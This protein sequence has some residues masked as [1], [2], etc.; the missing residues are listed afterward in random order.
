MRRPGL[1]GTLWPTDDEQLLLR[2]ALLPGPGAVTAWREVQPRF[3]YEAATK[4]E[5]RILPLVYRNLTGLGV[6]DPDLGKMKGLYR[7]AWYQNQLHLREAAAALTLL[8]EAGIDTLVLKGAPLALQC[9][10]ELGARP[11]GDV[12]L[13][14]PVAQR[15]EALATL[16]SQGWVPRPG[17]LRKSLGRHGVALY[18]PEGGVIDVHWQLS[19]AL[20]PPGDEDHA[21]DDFFSAS[22]ALDLAGTPARAPCLADTLLHVVVHGCHWRSGAQLHWI[23]D[24][25][26]LI[27]EGGDGLA[28]DRLVV[29]AEKRGVVLTVREGLRYLRSGV[30]APVPP[31]VL[32]TLGRSP[33]TRRDRL[34]HRARVQ[35]PRP[36]P[37][38]GELPAALALHVH[39]S[40]H[41]GPAG[42]VTSL[43]ASLQASWGLDHAWQL[44]VHAARRAG[45]R[46]RTPT[47]RRPD[48]TDR[49]G[50]TAPSG[51]P[52]R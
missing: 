27:R 28:W 21:S 23:T 25:V 2:A 5:Q 7:R 38:I 13:L 39:R 3:D 51:S 20:I 30:D 10:G 1:D 44:P 37:L 46:L 41:R 9:Y 6:D 12:D 14:V 47:R 11:M 29:Q 8:R 26:T 16:R 42:M 17:E 48:P 35:R 24:S 22:V 36:R 15:D 49:T 50:S 4:E 33:V 40:A 18:H 32:D 34:V 31:S 19:M 45:H 52:R 43:P